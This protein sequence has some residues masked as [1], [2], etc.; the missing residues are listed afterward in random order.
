MT[1]IK[2]N[3]L[4]RSAELSQQD[5]HAVR[6]GFAFKPDVNVNMN[7]TQ[8]IFQVQDIDVN[9]LNNNGAIGAGFVGPKIN[10]DAHLNAENKAIFPKFA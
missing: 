7:V 8:T 6:G 4:S 10:L 9:T 3:D 5:M 1:T 2:V